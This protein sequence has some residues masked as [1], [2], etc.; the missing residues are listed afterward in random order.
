[1]SDQP[2]ND[3]IREW[4]RRFAVDANN[5]AWTLSEQ[6]ELTADERFALL[7]AAHSSAYH[8]S[9]IGTNEQIAHAHLLLGRVHALLG[10]GDLAMEFAR[11]AFASI[12]SRECAPWEAAFA[13]GILANAAA[14]CGDGALHAHHYKEASSLGDRLEDP[15]ERALFHATFD[16]IAAPQ[17][18]GGE[19]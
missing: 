3:E 15:E 2:R 7:H 18:A 1:M 8:W 9:R 6:V 19:Q 4:H 14:A 5:E 16:L 10:K 12:T 11:M 17:P 13:H